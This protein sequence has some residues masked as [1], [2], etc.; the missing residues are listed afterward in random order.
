MRRATMRKELANADLII[1]EKRGKY[2]V[3]RV[4]RDTL[5]E[6]E[7]VLALVRSG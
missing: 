4:N 3:A 7:Q 6:V 5:A 1:T 2:L